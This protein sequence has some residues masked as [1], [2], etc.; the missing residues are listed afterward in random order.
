MQMTWL[1]YPETVEGL[2]AMLDT[3][4]NYTEKWKL[5]VNINKTKIIVFRIGGI[6]SDDEKW[7][8][9]GLQLETVNSFTYLG[10]VLNFNGKSSVAEKHVAE[11]GRKAVFAL[12]KNT[13]PFM[14][15]HHTLLSLFDT[16]ISSVLC[17]GCEIWGFHNTPD[18]E[19]VHVNY[20]KR[21]LK[22]KTSTTNI[23]VYYSKL[24]IFSNPGKITGYWITT[25]SFPYRGPY[26][27]SG[28]Y[29]PRLRLRPIWVSLF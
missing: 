5:S 24:S 27:G 14:F 4:Y 25:R 11:Q 19:K 21:I 17:Y 18:I 10:V 9:N 8:Y 29:G 16:Y 20:C 3:L 13:K 6:L 7:Y 15:N 28:Q 26:R 1:F 22:V 2:Q 12:I 23:M